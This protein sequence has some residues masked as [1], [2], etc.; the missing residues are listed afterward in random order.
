MYLSIS[1]MTLH[2]VL[3]VH[4]HPITHFPGDGFINTYVLF[5]FNQ[6]ISS[7]VTA[8]HLF[9]ILEFLIFCTSSQDFDSSTWQIF[10]LIPNQ[11]GD[12]P[13]LCYID[14]LSSTG[15]CCGMTTWILF[16]TFKSTLIFSEVLFSFC[17]I[18]FTPCSRNFTALDITTLLLPVYILHPLLLLSYLKKVPSMPFSSNFPLFVFQRRRNPYI[19]KS[20]R[21]TDSV[22]YYFIIGTGFHY[23][24]L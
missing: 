24:W 22:F 14:H 16:I 20:L 4:L 10:T 18:L 1:P 11:S 23:Y 21:G 5:S 9:L 3:N 6:L 2:F 7:S 12:T 15:A 17:L 13:L 8:N 19:R